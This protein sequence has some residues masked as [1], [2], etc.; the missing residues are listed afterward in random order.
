MAEGAFRLPGA[1]DRTTIIG[2]TGTGKT[3]MGGWVLSKQRFDKRPWVAIDFKGEVLWDMIGTPPVRDLRLGA[4]PG[5]RGLYRM[6]VN[7][8]QEDE[9]EDWMWKVW[10]HENIGLFI[11]EVS[12]VPQ[13]SAFK[14]LLRQGRTKLI[15]IISCTQRPVDCDREVFTES[16][17]ISVFALADV[18]DYKIIQGFTHGAAIDRPL[19]EHHSHWYDKRKRTLFALKPTPDPDSIAASLRAV[20]PRSWFQG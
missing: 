13:K 18:R 1:A 19:P 17:F 3:I 8:G 10:K 14:G 9:L 6:S 7:P 4:M 15:P 12:L 2:E 16:Q 5:N 11:D 20:A